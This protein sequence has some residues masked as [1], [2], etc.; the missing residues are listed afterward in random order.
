[1][2]TLPTIYSP[3]ITTTNENAIPTEDPDQ[4]HITLFTPIITTPSANETKGVT[5]TKAVNPNASIPTKYSAHA[6]TVQNEATRSTKPWFA[7]TAFASA[8]ATP[9]TVL[10]KSVSELNKGQLAGVIVGSVAGGLIVFYLFYVLC[11]GR[12]KA[13][14]K[15]RKEKE[16]RELDRKTARVSTIDLDYENEDENEDEKQSINHDDNQPI[17][18]PRSQPQYDPTRIYYP[19]SRSDPREDFKS[20]YRVS[21]NNTSNDSSLSGGSNTSLNVHNN[22]QP[23]YGG[24]NSYYG[25]MLQHQFPAFINNNNS[26][27]GKNMPLYAS[28]QS[29]LPAP[30]TMPVPDNA[31]QCFSPMNI[32]ASLNAAS[33]QF[34]PEVHNSPNSIAGFYSL[35]Y[36]HN[37]N[38]GSVVDCNKSEHC[39]SGVSSIMMPA[40]AE[41]E[42]NKIVTKDLSATVSDVINQV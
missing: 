8:S 33:Y 29:S 26:G 31:H 14:R 4:Y 3:I 21:L 18:L 42:D 41:D 6:L 1:M 13:L 40:V 9:P 34:N 27:F 23:F 37:S 12:R 30:L 15:A 36:V 2:Y 32:D 35:Q 28:Y 10:A 7:T 25:P 16:L 20:Y 5:R 11:W 39:A 22:L 19:T 17:S 38:T 24:F